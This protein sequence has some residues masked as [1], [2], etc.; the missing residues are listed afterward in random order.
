MRMFS[1]RGWSGSCSG[2]WRARRCATRASPWRSSW[3]NRATSPRTR[4][5]T[6]RSI[7][8]RWR[9]CS[10]ALP[11]S[12]TALRSC[13]ADSGRGNLAAQFEVAHGDLEPAFASAAR[14]GRGDA[15]LQRHAAV[16][17][18]PRGLVGRDRSPHR[19]SRRLGSGEDRARQP[20]ASS[21]GCW[22]SRRSGCAWSSSTSA[23]A[24]APA[25]RSTPRTS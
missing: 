1:R 4:S 24:S 22:A 5:S 15:A 21:P 3:R 11:R 14:G 17:S 10:K 12:R 23:A 9:R 13:F 20:T 19:W 7:T 6:S 2:R 18:R 16:A 25:A 8:S